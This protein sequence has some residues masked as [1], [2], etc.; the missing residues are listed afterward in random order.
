[1]AALDKALATA[2]T[3][4]LQAREEL[5][6][7]PA[8][9]FQDAFMEALRRPYEAAALAQSTNSSISSSS[10][11]METTTWRRSDLLDFLSLYFP[12][13]AQQPAAFSALCASLARKTAKA[14]IREDR[15][16][17]DKEKEEDLITASFESLKRV[18]V[19]QYTSTRL[20]AKDPY[21]LEPCV[22]LKPERR[23]SIAP[24]VPG[25]TSG[26][27][28]TSDDAE[29]NPVLRE[30]QAEV[31]KKSKSWLGRWRARHMLLRWGV[32]EMHKRSLTAR[33]FRHHSTANSSVP[34]SSS[35]SRGDGSGSASSTGATAAGAAAAA[36][37]KTYELQDLVSLK[38][39]HVSDG[40]S[41]S[42]RKAALTLKFQTSLTPSSNSHSNPSISASQDIKT[43]I[44]GGGEISGTLVS[45]RDHIATFALYLELSRRDRLPSMTKV[46]RYIA[47]GAMVN[48][49]VRIPRSSQSRDS[50]D[51]SRRRQVKQPPRGMVTALQ[52][53]FL[54]D[55]RVPSFESTI[56]LL[57]SAGA[58]PRSLLYWDY[59]TQVVFSPPSSV[60][61]KKEKSEE[62]H[63]R[64]RLRK[65]LLLLD[66]VESDGDESANFQCC[67]V[68]ADDGAR[69]N[70]LMYFCWLGD[71]EGVK[72]LLLVSG[73]GSSSGSQG[74]NSNRQV[75]TC[76]D[77]VN[78]AGDTALHIA[79][80][81]SNESVALLLVE[82]AL[83]TNAQA[84]HR[85]DARGEPV[86]HLALVARQWRVVDAL[87]SGGAVDPRSY[88]AL[89]NTALHLAIQLRA[90]VA[91]IARLIQV[92][93]HSP[94][95][96][97]LDG[98]AGRRG[99]TD[100]P[101]SLALKAGQQEVVALLLASGASP[102]GSDCQW[103]QAFA[104]KRE[105]R[106]E[107]E[108]QE[109]GIVG[110][111]DS[112]LHIAIKAGMELAA[113]AL[114]AHKADIYAVDSRGASTLALA[115]RYGLYAL[116]AALVDQH[117]KKPN[118]PASRHWWTDGETGRPVVMLAL[119]AGQL[120]LAALLLDC[121]SQDKDSQ[122]QM[123]PARLLPLLVQITSWLGMGSDPNA[124]TASSNSRRKS[125]GSV[126]DRKKTRSASSNSIE[127][128]SKSRSG[129]ARKQLRSETPVI[130]QR[131][132]ASPVHEDQAISKQGRDS[133][134]FLLRGI[135]H[136]V[137]RFLHISGKT[138]VIDVV[139]GGTTP[140]SLPLS[141]LPLVVHLPTTTTPSKSVPPTVFKD[142]TLHAGS[143][144][145]VAAS[146]GPSTSSLLRLFLAF[147]QN[148]DA[149]VAAQVLVRPMGSRAETSLH[150]ALAVGA[151]E[152]A[153]LLLYS[154]R[155]L[156]VRSPSVGPMCAQLLEMADLLGDTALH[157][158]SA[159]P[160]S[161]AMRFAVELL[162]QE[163][164]DAGNWNNAGL[165]P[166][167]VALREV[168]DGSFIE[169]FLRYGQDLNLW[170]EGSTYE[171]ED[172]SESNEFFSSGGIRPSARTLVTSCPQN[173]LM[174]A[175]ESDNVSAF[176]ALIHGGARTRALMP[177]ARVGLL[178]LAVH[179]DV[180]DPE[181]L[182]CLLDDPELEHAAQ[183]DV[184]DQWGVSPRDARS[185]L[186]DI[187]SK[188]RSGVDHQGVDNAGRNTKDSFEGGHRQQQ[189]PLPL[190]PSSA[191]SER[192]NSMSDSFS[193]SMGSSNQ[194]L[195]V[196]VP[197]PLRIN[198]PRPPA[199]SMPL[200]TAQYLRAL[201]RPPTLSST[202][203]EYLREEER[204]TLTLVAQEA[205][206]EAQDWLAKRIGQKKLLSDAHAQLQ[207]AKK[208]RRTASGSS[209]SSNRDELESEASGVRLEC[210]PSDQQLLEELKA[211]AAK[212]F[213][214]KHVAEA[215]AEA[216]LLIER[217]KQ[218]IF[219][220]TGLY[221]GMTSTS[222]KHKKKGEGK[223]RS[224][225]V[226]AASSTTGSMLLPASSAS[227]TSVSSEEGNLT[228]SSEDSYGSA[229]FWW[230]DR[231]TTF[232]SDDTSLSWLSSS[233]PRGGTMLSDPTSASISSWASNG[234]G[235]MLDGSFDR[236][237]TFTSRNFL[238][239]DDDRYGKTPREEDV[240]H[241]A[242][243]PSQEQVER[244]TKY[245]NPLD[246]PSFSHVISERNTTGRLQQ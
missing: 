209:V 163:H 96:G 7:L 94:P 128:T 181:L 104:E 204:A 218:T 16:S 187:W 80:K 10:S 11:G 215:V 239:G 32:L 122:Q 63:Q 109:K 234:R 237:L 36:N 176:R 197:P 180:R 238:D 171:D 97:G 13:Y 228:Q 54:Q 57:L 219:Q 192:F 99:T 24:F 144:L 168:C 108:T 19:R 214:D 155:E 205:R 37:T 220:E 92:Y 8:R 172:G 65:R 83:S 147:L 190:H 134:N 115:V 5:S 188:E 73:A 135:H 227:V 22:E 159:W 9:S 69:W 84:V 41:A 160:H 142:D 48:V 34:S 141:T 150:A 101:L 221:P 183:S 152:N 61:D 136:L 232:L 233:N 49:R 119:Q 213:I 173:P 145:H 40:E 126:G 76:L 212:T 139:G 148:A 151:A 194:T 58:D 182:A 207:N 103:S 203:L 75:E 90:P 217:E 44:L 93:R 62:H 46:R 77:H 208:H 79:I 89:G 246:R 185:R 200:E 210:A 229:S 23:R 43:L 123:C 195:D 193:S 120:E 130:E 98:R 153:L 2:H 242:A 26:S 154:S 186:M 133:C 158:A 201:P 170:T 3:Q 211:A 177:R 118:S 161:A 87:V 169:L 64:R 39:E 102:S 121:I 51:G 91:L 52:L 174:L 28:N 167:H 82:A 216:R 206:S 70:L 162:L 202:T 157:L 110:D 68:Q 231:G 81:A 224:L 78:A 124:S 138:P 4:L 244:D 106:K 149:S 71:L 191:S 129:E 88:D 225:L 243:G 74:R 131:F 223:H 107:E 31:M 116:A 15:K 236:R 25:P 47:A 56:A 199:E 17:A 42:V 240:D 156:Q 226:R 27:D 241:N 140:I 111:E 113:A 127:S 18:L 86:V 14:A 38:L 35:S 1:M 146:G 85:C 164:V 179:F 66:K 55:P 189:R 196:R 45:I 67:E 137:V 143:P 235:T 50:K 21:P 184:A 53:A 29:T 114:I 132:A 198:V 72:Q 230:S 59:A 175:L 165:A 166:L 117:Q 105:S 33:S 60:S 112:A 95:T 245:S 6:Q 125:G 178:Q 222:K 30:F 12:Q 100:T 20:V